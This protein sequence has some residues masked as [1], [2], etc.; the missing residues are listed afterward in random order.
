MTLT[1]SN[2]KFGNEVAIMILSQ[3]T[4]QPH[5]TVSD[6]FQIGN[7]SRDGYAVLGVGLHEPFLPVAYAD[8]NVTIYENPMAFPRTFLVNNFLVVTSQE[9]A[10]LKTNQLGWNTR[11]VLVIEEMPYPE[12]LAAIYGSAQDASPGSSEIEGYS[13][14]EVVIFSKAD[15]ATFL[16]LTDLY[17]PGWT[18]YI[19][20]SPAKVYRAYGALRAVFIN[21]GSHE[22]MFRYEPDSFRRGLFI[23]SASVFLI[24]FLCAI[25]TAPKLARRYRRFVP[26]GP[27]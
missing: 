20:G 6:S 19:D 3:A 23:T 1:Q 9:Q 7:E 4:Q 14:N 22:V 8:Q 16:V 24:I 21:P 25:H 10:M 17:Y 11:N 27:P 2:G 5:L 26:I 12:E 13:E 18:C 15:A